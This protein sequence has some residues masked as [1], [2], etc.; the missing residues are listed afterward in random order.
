MNE[1]EGINSFNTII[2]A[3]RVIVISPRN[4]TYRGKLIS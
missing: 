3:I 2:Q 1:I 4:Y